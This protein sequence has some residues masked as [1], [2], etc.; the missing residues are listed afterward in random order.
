M[1]KLFHLLARDFAL[2][3]LDCLEQFETY[4][5]INT[6]LHG[7]MHGQGKGRSTARHQ[8]TVLCRLLMSRRNNVDIDTELKDL[9][10]RIPNASNRF[11]RIVVPI[12]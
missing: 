9:V 2:P 1:L 6:E 5:L 8:D 4:G 7:Q 10:I 11:V 3:V 12:K